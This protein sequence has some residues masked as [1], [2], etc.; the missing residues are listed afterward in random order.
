MTATWSAL[1]TF[2][3]RTSAALGH[4]TLAIAQPRQAAKPVR[5]L[6]MLG[7]LLHLPACTT[8][9]GLA[10]DG[11]PLL[12]RLSSPDVGHLL[13]AGATGSG[14]TELMRTTLLSL[15][16]THRQPR[17]PM[18][19]IDPEG[20]GFEP[21][22]NLP[23]LLAPV[24]AN[25]GDASAILNRL[26]AEEERRDQA[27]ASTPLIVLAIDELAE[28]LA[29][30]GKPAETALLCLAQ[31]GRQAGIH[32][33]VS[34]WQAATPAMQPILTLLSGRLVGH[35]GSGAEAR[36]AS[37]LPA[38]GAEELLGR[39]DFLALAVGQKV[40]FQAAWIPAE[41]WPTALHRLAQPHNRV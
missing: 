41:E 37:G 26:M 1:K 7:R 38:S 35:V 15:A 22:A 16:L 4:G 6:W 36:A 9:L 5:L 40:H 18:A 11:R 19:L 24:G 17:L 8:C 10:E 31:R 21:L 23:H 30:A 33:V 27:A 3:S 39:R 29:H 28:L 13:V 12:V 14:Q 2:T 20:Q 34:A 25:P 32:L